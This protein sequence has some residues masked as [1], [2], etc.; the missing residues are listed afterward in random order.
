MAVVR[1]CGTMN[2]HTQYNTRTCIIYN[3]LCMHAVQA[4]PFL[5]LTFMSLSFMFMMLLLMF[6]HIARIFW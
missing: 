3:A 5:K 4:V 2:Y 6:F 1:A